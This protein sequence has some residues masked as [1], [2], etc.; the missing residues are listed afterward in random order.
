MHTALSGKWQEASTRHVSLPEA[1]PSEFEVYLEWLYTNH[2]D[3][4]DKS[5]NR[6]MTL[7]RLYL[8]GDYLGDD[9][10]M[11]AI[12]DA[13]VQES[14]PTSPAMSF[15]AAD[16][17]TVWQ[18]TLPDSKLR[19]ALTDLIVHEI[20]S[21]THHRLFRHKGTWPTEI[22]AEILTR[23]IGSK[24]M[25]ATMYAQI[26]AQMQDGGGLK[27]ALESS[28]EHPN[29]RKDKCEYHR[30]DEGNPRCTADQ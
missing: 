20:G 19:K 11:N 16:V 7:V 25:T 3:I 15:S 8:L 29:A 26:F 21:S 4:L 9:R 17:D 30:H 6:G 5:S 2:I 10:F 23:M 24:Q 18:K 28:G 12:I 14:L 13:L 22:S 27:K 1:S